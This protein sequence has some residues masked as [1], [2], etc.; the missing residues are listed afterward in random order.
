VSQNYSLK[1]NTTTQTLEMRNFPKHDLIPLLMCKRREQEKKQSQPQAS[2]QQI[3]ENS[4]SHPRRPT[5]YAQQNRFSCIDRCPT[6]HVASP[7]EEKKND[8]GLG[9][10]GS[11]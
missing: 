2:H 3:I 6:T 11:S 1:K 9:L 7:R 10:L 8:Q 4:P 5:K